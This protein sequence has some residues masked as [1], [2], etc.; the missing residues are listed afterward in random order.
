[1]KILEDLI[2]TNKL[3]NKLTNYYSCLNICEKYV[4]MCNNKGV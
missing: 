1:M 3:P 4:N 2:K